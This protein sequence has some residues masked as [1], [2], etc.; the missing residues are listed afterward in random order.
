MTQPPVHRIER[1]LSAF[2]ASRFPAGFAGEYLLMGFAD[3]FENIL[4]ALG[5]H[6]QRIV[7]EIP[8]AWPA[9]QNRLVLMIG[10]DA[11]IRKLM[12]GYYVR[13]VT[14][15]E[16]FRSFPGPYDLIAVIGTDRDRELWATPIVFNALPKIYVLGEDGHNDAIVAAASSRGYDAFRHGEYLIL[17]HQ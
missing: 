4:H 3:E 11:H 2:L 15:E 12:P 9:T 13:M 8:S 6:G 7:E 1:N 10:P 16:V 5:W 17:V 14:M